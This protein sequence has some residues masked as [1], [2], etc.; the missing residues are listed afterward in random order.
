VGPITSPSTFTTDY[1][2]PKKNSAEH[3]AAKIA[4]EKWVV[5]MKIIKQG[6]KETK[7]A[8][9][10]RLRKEREQQEKEHQMVVNRM[11]ERELPS[12]GEEIKS[13]IIWSLVIPRVAE[14][15]ACLVRLG[16]ACTYLYQKTSQDNLWEGR[17]RIFGLFNDHAA[18]YPLC[19]WKM[20]ALSKV[21]NSEIFISQRLR[22]CDMCGR[23]VLS[24]QIMNCN[25]C[26]E[27]HCE[28]CVDVCYGY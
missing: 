22:S 12:I 6:E 3:A 18:A 19:S 16:L 15:I 27:P 4:L 26:S 25:V 9:K 23:S 11:M 13:R 7:E 21:Q 8:E 10:E 20:T 2:Y 14:K 5:P 24:S 17:C 1:C 28:S